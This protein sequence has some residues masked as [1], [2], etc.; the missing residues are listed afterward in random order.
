M[1]GRI[2][3]IH[4]LGQDAGA[5][6]ETAACVDYEGVFPD[7]AKLCEGEAV[8]Y[9]TLSRRFE[10]YCGAEDGKLVLCRLSLGGI[11]AM[12]Y[13][14]RHPD[15]VDRLILAGIQYRMPARLLRFQNFLFRL[16]PE[17]AFPGSGFGKMDFIS[18]SRSMTE[19]DFTDELKKIECPA[20]VICGE[21]DSA[22]QTAC[23]EAAGLLPDGRLCVIQGA[24]HELNC[25]HPKELA[26]AITKFI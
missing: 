19:L 22:N 17:S 2:V 10:E 24:G 12:D 13:A 26:E 7:L 11:L 1:M 21:K 14:I 25:S 15:R 8:C 9:K 16:M 3:Y 23:K 4:G 20:L 6:K 5:W 18:L